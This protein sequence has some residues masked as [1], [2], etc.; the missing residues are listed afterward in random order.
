M[1]MFP[2]RPERGGNA[3]LRRRGDPPRPFGGAVIRRAH[4]LQDHR[5]GDSGQEASAQT[6]GARMLTNDK[7]AEAI[8][9]VVAARSEYSIL[10]V[11]LRFWQRAPGFTFI[12]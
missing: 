8:R 1:Q 10:L 2:A 4:H 5:S 3:P 11:F 12:L 9:E 6:Q 7:V